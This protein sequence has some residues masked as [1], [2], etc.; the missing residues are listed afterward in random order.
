VATLINTNLT[1]QGIHE[2]GW[3]IPFLLGG[4][5]G[6]VA[7]YLRRWL[8]ERLFSSKCSSARR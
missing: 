7:M 3:R 4:A 1:P 2:G 8:Q 5:F 6:L